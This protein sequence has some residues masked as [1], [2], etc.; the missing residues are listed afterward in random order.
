MCGIAGIFLADGAGSPHALSVTAQA[1][2]DALRQRGPDD[3]GVW[4]DPQGGIALSHRRLA[5]IDL[6]QD[7]HQP[8]HSAS[9]RYVLSYN[10]EIYNYRELRAQLDYPWR[11]ESDTQ[12]ILA[13]IEVWGIETALTKLNGMFAFALWDRQDRTLTLARDHMGEKPLYYGWVNNQFVFASE[14][15]A[16]RAIPGWP[17][18]INHDALQLFMRYS[19]I[20]A[21]YSVYTGIHQLPP[22]NYLTLKTGERDAA[23]RAYWSL[24]D[25]ILSNRFTGNEPEAI[26]ALDRIFKHSVNQRMMSDVP[27]GAFLSG[28][29][30]SSAI[31]ALMQAQSTRPI[32]TFTIG[33]SESGFDEAPYAKAIA[34]HLGTQHTEIYLTP[35]DAAAA[36]P[37]LPEIYDEPFADAS[38]IPTY[39]VSKFARQ[40]VTVALSGDGGD[41]LFG[42]YNRHIRA[43]GLWHTLSFIPLPLR[44]TAAKAL[45]QAHHA[46]IHHLVP[47]PTTRVGRLTR[48]L[49]GYYEK[50]GAA[51]AA[52]FY[53]KLCSI[54]DHP[55]RLVLNSTA[56]TIPNYGD[57]LHLNFAEWMMLQDALT[58]FPGDILTKVDRAAM[59]NSLETRTPFTDPAL[60]EF[61]W[62]LPQHLKIRHGQGKYLLRQLLSRYMPNHLID[63]PKA[64]FAIPI[65]NW[66][67]GDLKPWAQDLLSPATIAAQGYLNPAE[68][69]NIWNIHQ[70][71]RADCEKQ[72][73][74]ILMFQSWL[75]HQQIS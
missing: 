53:H 68:V 43:P 24:T 65:G 50:I 57:D 20:P 29:I 19:Y 51:S 60:M 52:D 8:M 56:S 11:G 2:A 48:K 61:A 70:S 7:G 44:R 47:N 9:G 37:K 49:V 75:Q 38:Q 31:A 27:L 15:K 34:Q 4:A 1:M 59:A 21:P 6:T 36:I 71:G 28:G 46:L 58:Y 5:I 42:G 30:D 12:V 39:L 17:P 64:G 16:F 73:W 25:I 62:S 13:A 41:E 72:L 63:R 40:H 32:K 33:F 54:H 26:D 74:N 14:L 10:G 67:R 35:R 23:P 18:A 69:E 66:L 3:A 45:L 22:A 55:E